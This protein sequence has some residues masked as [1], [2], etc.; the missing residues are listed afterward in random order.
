MRDPIAESALHSSDPVRAAR[1]LTNLV[2]DAEIPEQELDAYDPVFLG[3]LADLLI[4]S[5]PMLDA[6]RRH[7]EWLNWLWHNHDVYSDWNAA[8][9]GPEG[10]WRKVLSET[11][12]GT[13]I[14]EGLR[15]FKARETLG[16]LF[17]DVGGQASFRQTVRSI[18]ALA[19]L[20]VTETL[21]C[22]WQAMREDVP[23]DLKISPPVPG[24]FLVI[25]MGK[26]GAQELN[27]SSDIDL[28]FCRRSSDSDAE[29]RFFTRLG[30]RIIQELGYSGPDG[31]LYRVDM[32]LRPH[33][34][35][36]PLVPTFPSLV[37]YYE[38]WSEAWERQAL[39][40]ARPV[41]GPVDLM[42]RFSEFAS[43]FTFARPMDDSAL[44]EIKRVKHRAEKEHALCENRIH[45]KHGSGGI[46]DIEFY[47]QYL[48][49]I[50]GWENPTVR[51][52]ATLDALEG[53][54]DARILLEGESTTLSLAYVF[55]RTVEHRLQVRALTPQAV[56]PGDAD[57][58][59]ALAAGI[60]FG[61][62]RDSARAEFCSILQ[63][64]RSR[65][66]AI[67][68]RIYL[69]PGYLRLTEKEE[70][71]ARLLSERTPKEQIRR[72]LAQY[73][74]EDIDLAW[75]N[76][77]L[78]A[79]GPAGEILPPRERRFFLEFAF[80]MLEVLRDSLDPDLALHHLESF[81]AA[82]GNRISFLRTLASRR[83][84][85]ARLA[86]LLAFSRRACHIL[87][88]HPEYF[89]SLAR[90][91][92]LHEGRAREEMLTEVRD[93]LSTGPS[94]AS[95]A[96]ILRYYRQREMV[97]IAYRDM[98][99][100][101]KPMEISA[102][103]TVLAEACVQAAAIQTQPPAPGASRIDDLCVLALG[104]LGSGFMHYGSDLDL[105]FLY[106]ASAE[107][108]DL[109][110]RAEEQLELDGRVE[111]INEMI[112]AVTEQGIVYSV[113]MRLRP[114][115]ASG[116]L[117]RSWEGFHEYAR[118]HI[119]PWERFAMVRSRVIYG[120][121]RMVERWAEVMKSYVYEYPWTEE[122]F[123]ALRHLK[124][125]IENEK[126]K[127][128]RISVDFKFGKGGI[129][130]LEFLVQWLQIRHG[131]NR[132]SVRGPSLRRAIAGLLHSG[133]LTGDEASMLLRAHD[134]HRMIENR[135]QL[136]EEWN[137]REISRESPS[138]ALLA[139][140]LGYRGLTPSDSR[141]AL[142]AE[143]EARSGPVRALV[144][145]YIF[146]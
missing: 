1:A 126:S 9:Q 137:A 46:R 61:P 108:S 132:D 113:D 6:F 92:H 75:R 136:M 60:G 7:P 91:I 51:A 55:L 58:L 18:S 102:E 122:M 109:T 82:S 110:G 26:L 47:V 142:L 81:A 48:Q 65:V 63:M 15:C 125:R 36:G 105:M 104:K 84:H 40:K 135:Y 116:L 21:T 49:L 54:A 25:A 10:R 70:E 66:R 67:L 20:V 30:E 3:T 64:H 86:N 78:I 129:L 120:T 62:G 24:G 57:E 101:G 117:A 115:G 133:I 59:A 85:L 106:E 19:N 53:L 32:R 145:K 31:F 128:S 112:S 42:R 72:L 17:A 138:L 93:R 134:L 68:E 98:A 94:G 144:E 52:S 74:F 4:V 33:G 44:E 139:K 89:D 97:R 79:M 131:R 123:S 71:L 14:M 124:R 95:A 45:L 80:P 87:L 13:G 88:R 37:S 143:W 99:G 11:A 100:L 118:S 90:G 27:Y 140:S 39:I 130:D 8:D 5:P 119:Q 114:E 127:E 111:K 69:T 96:A 38:S 107:D 35:T 22:S 16:I 28:I 50:S 41:A 29:R 34:E 2:Q 76:I 43:K 141:H 103:L 73:G 121:P 56:I 83:P 23:D 77:R 12:P 146:G